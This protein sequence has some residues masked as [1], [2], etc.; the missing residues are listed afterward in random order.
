MNKLMLKLKRICTGLINLTI[1]NYIFI[2]I[3]LCKESKCYI[4]DFIVK[5]TCISNTTNVEVFFIYSLFP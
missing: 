3:I 5:K 1:P 4:T 2:D